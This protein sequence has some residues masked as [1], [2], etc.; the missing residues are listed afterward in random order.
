MGGNVGF[1]C[2]QTLTWQREEGSVCW[3][4]VPRERWGRVLFEAC[5]RL[6]PAVCVCTRR[7]GGQLGQHLLGGLHAH[8][9]RGGGLDG[10]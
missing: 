9:G 1:S 8:G 5:C 2:L 6:W 4:R 7:G 3:P 10:G